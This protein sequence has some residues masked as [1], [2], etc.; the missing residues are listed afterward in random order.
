MF[1]KYKYYNHKC[2][3]GIISPKSYEII[4]K[5]TTV[6]SIK[7][8]DY[9]DVLTTPRV[10]V[11]DKDKKIIAKQ[12]SISQLEDYLD[13]LQKVKNPV[14]IIPEDPKEAEDAKH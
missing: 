6:E 8:D 3:V 7:Y 13:N 11:L 5:Y 10:F 9:Y 1:G 4:P 12:L 14:K 2:T